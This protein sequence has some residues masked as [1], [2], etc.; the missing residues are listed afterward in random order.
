MKPAHSRLVLA[1]TI[2]LAIGSAC[3]TRPRTPVLLVSIDTLR[4]DHLG[5]YGYSRPTS[6]HLDVFRKDAVLFQK[7]I[8]HAPSTLPSHASLLTSML[9]PHHGASVANGLAVPKE[10]VTLAEVLH[11]EGYATASFNGGIQLDPVWG[12]DQGFDT[13]MSVKPRG[14]PAE[15]LV[16]E[17]DRF[18][19][20][21]EQARAWILNHEARPFFLFL[22]TY[23]VHH[24]YSPETADLDPFRGD[25][26]GP[27]PDRI[28]MDL[29][30]EIDGGSLKVSDRDRQHLVDAYDGEIRSMDRAYGTLVSFLKERGLYDAA[31]VLVTSDHGEEF[32][33]HGRL[34]WH[35]HSLF[36]ELLRVPL[37]VKLP[38]SR[39][40]GA[41]V[42]DQVRG[43]DVAPTILS[44]LGLGL[45]A[46]FEGRPL[47][48]DGARAG[49]A[50]EAW[51]SRDVTEPNAFISLRTP[52]WKLLEGRLFDLVA[53]PGE[54]NDVAKAHQDVVRR[55]AERRRT[56]ERDRPRA[57]R[58]PASPDD[59]LRE[60]LRSLGYVE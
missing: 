6:P 50:S 26:E 25:Y 20:V 53:D 58:R 9:P 54:R 56:L 2:V 1:A 41:A 57:A 3:R 33:E 39:L 22:H 24:P 13:Y 4:P 48:E 11:A 44:V 16:D 29:L 36:D 28:T 49:V 15:S 51:S 27:L 60:R 37:L 42:A 23:E 8:A 19:F 35:S 34:G 14:A 47:L 32:G 31:L 21:V 30:R 45:P 17:H 46:T 38:R 40:A 5:C 18:S 52:E 59:G 12:L 43:I 55:L 10:I 7:A